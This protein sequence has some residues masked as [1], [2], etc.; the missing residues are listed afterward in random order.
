MKVVATE[1]GEVLMNASS[2]QQHISV[3]EWRELERKSHDVKHEY[4][5]G[6]VY[7]MSGG[8]LNHSRISLNACFALEN[9]LLTA[10]KQCYVS[11]NRSFSSYITSMDISSICTK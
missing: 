3:D 2:S 7:A 10:G 11:S 8:S 9:A 5:D 6:R 4:I 1:K